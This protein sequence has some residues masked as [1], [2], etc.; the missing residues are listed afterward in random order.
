MT[1]RSALLPHKHVRF[2]DSLLALAGYVRTLLN[3]PRTIDELWTLMGSADA[4]WPTHPTFNQL[5]L[6][7]DVLFALSELQMLS[8]GRLCLV[9]K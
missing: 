4:H 5:M 6:A 2:C 1:S 9:L 3:Q 8:D 7:V